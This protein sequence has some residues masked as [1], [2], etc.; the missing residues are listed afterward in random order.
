MKPT[1]LLIA[2]QEQA[3]NTTST[4]LQAEYRGAITAAHFED[5]ET[6]FQALRTG[7]GVY[8]LGFRAKVALMGNDRVR[9][10]NG[11]VSNKIKDLPEGQGVYAFVLNPQGHILADLYAYNRGEALVIDTDH[12]QLEK[13]LAI[14]KRYIIMDKVEVKD[15]SG[16]ITAVGV[17]GPKSREVLRT[18]GIEVPE[19]T[20]LQIVTPQCNCACDCLQCWLVRSDAPEESY[21]IWIAP[22]SVQQVW[23]ALL[24]A[25]AT[26]VGSDAVEKQRIISGI[27]LYGV[28]IRERELPHETEQMRG[29]HFQKGCY[30]GQE[31]VERIRSRGGVHRRFAGFIGEGVGEITPGHRISFSGKDVGE[32]TSVTSLRDPEGERTVALGYIRREIGSA[33]RE[34][35]IGERNAIVAEMP[36]ATELLRRERAV[37]HQ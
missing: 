23:N 19:M 24:A 14:F 21:E 30:I 33:G 10:L 18:A 36:L 34:V 8:D 2:L 20:P 35:L 15:L 28:D 5:A 26:A 37:A 7:C 13:L 31:I 16:E 6:E 32:I 22:S 9:W 1:S 27:P 29:L 25:G 3:G 17:A 4:L 11:M 12:S